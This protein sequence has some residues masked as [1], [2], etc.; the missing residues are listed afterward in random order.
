MYETF[1]PPPPDYCTEQRHR[2]ACESLRKRIAILEGFAGKR[3]FG[4]FEHPDKDNAHV[5]LIK[6][7]IRSIGPPCDS[8]QTTGQL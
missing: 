4:P 5:T 8:Q 7:A 2:E 6:G 3:L 1:H